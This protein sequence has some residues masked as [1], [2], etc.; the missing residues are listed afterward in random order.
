M[1]LCN[2]YMP[3]MKELY[4]LYIITLCIYYIHLKYIYVIYTFHIYLFVYKRSI[5]KRELDL[6][7]SKMSII[8]FK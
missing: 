4:V 6:H 3:N 8:Y 7:V 1:Y 2:T 5:T